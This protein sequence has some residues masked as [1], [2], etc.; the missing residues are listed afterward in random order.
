MS[1]TNRALI[2]IF[3]MIGFYVLALSVAA[4]L[5]WI[6]YAEWHYLERLSPRLALGCILSAGLILWSISPRRDRFETPGP[7]IDATQQPAL[8]AELSN[9]AR[10]VGQEMPHE[11]Y[12]VPEVNAWVAQRGGVMAF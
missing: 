5:L 7:R 2:A 1:L 3:L 9:I 6:P 10:S 11:V 4:G 8:F 12:L